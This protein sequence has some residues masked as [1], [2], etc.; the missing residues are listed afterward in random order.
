VRRRDAIRLGLEGGFAVL[1]GAVPSGAAAAATRPDYPD[2]PVHRAH[3]LEFRLDSAY[4]PDLSDVAADRL[5]RVTLEFIRGEHPNNRTVTFW[6]LG[7]NDMPYLP[8]H[9]ENVVEHTFRGVRDTLDIRP[10]D[11]IAILSVL[12][13]ESR[14]HPKVLSPAGAMG[15]AQFM[16]DTAVQFGMTP[17]ARM[18]LWKRYQEARQR[19]RADRRSRLRAFRSQH[20]L[21]ARDDEAVIRRALTKK[22]LAILA[23]YVS[24]LDEPDPSEDLKREYIT[25]LEADLSKHHFFWSG[26]ESLA[27]IDSRA[28]YLAVERSVRYIALQLA[29]YQGMVST[30]VAA[31]NA[32]PDA[33][34]VRSPHSILY[35]FGDIPD[36]AETIK[37]VQ[38]FLA[39]YV[40]LKQRVHDNI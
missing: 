23:D 26:Q 20:S 31:Y 10:V 19:Y 2:S 30:A 21:P 9:L 28:S 22:S 39:V 4:R 27:A 40:A 7:P 12:Y 17:V 33:V 1:L 13:N 25:R 8:Q 14:F 15:M 37:Y 6:K 38:R 18:D 5:A 24:I 16:P 29:D 36:Y 3:P 32:G 11:P 35:R 34:R